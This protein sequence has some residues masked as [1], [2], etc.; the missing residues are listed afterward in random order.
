MRAVLF[1]IALIALP[2]VLPDYHVYLATMVCNYVIVAIGL[3]I[4]SGMCGLPSFGQAGFYAI[5]AYVSALLMG[6]LGL[7]FAVSLVASI[8]CSAL[9]GMLVALPAMRLHGFALAITTFGFAVL[10]QAVI[11]YFGDWTGGVS[12]YSVPPV[13]ISDHGTLDLYFLNAAAALAVI[14]ISNNIATG[15]I[16]RAFFAIRGSETAARAGGVNVQFFKVLA[17]AIS[18][19]CAGLAGSLYGQIT[20]YI[21]P[22]TFDATLSVYFFAMVVIGG[23]GSKMGAV[24]GA[25]FFVLLP[26]ALRDAK[27]TQMIIF[28]A[29]IVLV[30]IFLPDGLAG[31]FAKLGQRL[32]ALMKRP[33]NAIKPAHGGHR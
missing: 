10:V 11:I 32:S 20:Q 17:F 33:A 30:S 1:L 13:Q 27:D 19:G 18:S 7:P 29:S 14:W 12:G 8:A 16:G 6:H 26:E 15:K 23:M 31:M 2:F 9:L 5:G 22:E 3:N 25:I 4:L 28:G 21:S 24:I